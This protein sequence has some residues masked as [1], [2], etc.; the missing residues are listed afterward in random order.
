MKEKEL[1]TLLTELGLS[2]KELAVE[3]EV[4]AVSG[5][6]M[7]MISKQDLGRIIESLERYKAWHRVVSNI[8]VTMTQ[9]RQ[10]QDMK[11]E[12]GDIERLFND[13]LL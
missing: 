2:Y 10:F 12:A 7:I 1:E 3:G 9:A 6:E 11:F 4:V 8:L 5:G 13:S